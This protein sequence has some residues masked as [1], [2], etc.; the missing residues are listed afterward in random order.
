M[1]Q[2]G[3]LAFDHARPRN[4]HQAR[5]AEDHRAGRYLMFAHDT[6]LSGRTLAERS[7]TAAARRA[8]AARMS[9]RNSGWQSH[10]R[11]RSSGWNWQPRNHGWPGSSM[12]ATSW[13]S[14]DVPVA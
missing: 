1:A 4:Q 3:L 7:G 9:P 13:S 5:S 8:T 12:I 11:E 10:G 6:A 2:A 14:G